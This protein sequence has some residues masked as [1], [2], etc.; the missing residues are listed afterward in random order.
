MGWQ[1]LLQQPS[2][3]GVPFQVDSD[4]MDIG[5]R[6]ET[7]EYPQRDKPSTE[8]YG[9]RKREIKLRAWVCGDD[10]VA[11]RDALVAAI[12]TKGAG[13]LIHPSFGEMNVNATEGCRVSHNDKDGRMAYFDLEFVE[14]GERTFPSA[15][16]NT[17]GFL[18][19]LASGLQ[20]R[21]NS[22]FAGVFKG[23][24]LSG[25]G[26][27]KITAEL[28]TAYKWVSKSVG[29]V[30]G[31]SSGNGAWLSMVL[32]YL[33][34]NIR[35][36]IKLAMSFV[37]LFS[38][39]KDAHTSAAKTLN[40]TF[41]AAARANGGSGTG[42]VLA[43]VVSPREQMSAYAQGAALARAPQA[44]VQLFDGVRAAQNIDVSPAVAAQQQAVRVWVGINLITHA[45]ELAAATPALVCDDMLATRDAILSQIDALA[46][47]VPDELFGDWQDL[48]MAVHRD[49]T[50]RALTAQ[51]LRTYRLN[52][53]MPALVVAYEQQGNTSSEMALVARN[54][55]AHPLFVQ[56]QDLK[57]S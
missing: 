16:T 44:V 3:R 47:E 2:F 15:A 26:L 5:R 43:A 13:V 29:F 34:A 12:E 46:G 54:G 51:R 7:F 42:S 6:T 20:G 48:R 10:W 49:L 55:V 30:N 40:T 23:T 28:S 39:N 19:G 25:W 35:A 11:Q 56:A 32:A 9:R 27:N 37:G 57:V 4:D 45:A 21:V 33:P 14:D 31:I 24:S 22:W 38:S 52:R 50:T 8:D 18:D 1:D 53:V 36:P 17:S 41:G